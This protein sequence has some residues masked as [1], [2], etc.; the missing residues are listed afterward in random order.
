[1]LWR[2][3]ITDLGR[4]TLHLCSDFPL[5]QMKPLTTAS[6]RTSTPQ[7]RLTWVVCT[8]HHFQRVIGT[9]LLTFEEMS[10]LFA[11]IEA[12]LNSRHLTSFSVSDNDVE[13][14]TPAHVLISRSLLSVPGE[15]AETQKLVLSDQ[16]RSILQL[17]N[18]FWH[19]LTHEYLRTLQRQTKWQ[20]AAKPFQ[21]GDFSQSNRQSED[22]VE[23]FRTNRLKWKTKQLAENFNIPS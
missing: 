7:P 6:N 16:C 19:Q 3:V 1:M 13:A 9:Q 14:L 10:T 20:A 18:S 22:L 21:V 17:R 5:K 15:Y 2:S 11:Q 4:K 8:K 12:I 23:Y